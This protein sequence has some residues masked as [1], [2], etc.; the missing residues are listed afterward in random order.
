MAQSEYAAQQVREMAIKEP[1]YGQIGPDSLGFQYLS[2][3]SNQKRFNQLRLIKPIVNMC[4]V[5][6][7]HVLSPGAPKRV[8]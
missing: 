4:E 5:G 6:M 2:L 3:Q 7:K 1:P 8:F